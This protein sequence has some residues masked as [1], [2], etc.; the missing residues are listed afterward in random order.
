MQMRSA[1]RNADGL[2]WWGSLLFLMVCLCGCG[3]VEPVVKI[4]LV[5]PF[6]GR[7]RPVGYDV[8]Y[9]GRL[10]VRQV[11]Q[12]G[13][14]GDYRVALV[15][16]D[17]SGDAELA[18]EVAASLAIDPGVVAVIG[19]WRPETTAAAGPI[20]AEAGLPYIDAT[21]LE[22]IDPA[23]LPADFRFAYEAVTPF[24][25]T[26]GEY[27]GPAYADFET[28]LAALAAA[29]AEY[30]RIDRTTVGEIMNSNE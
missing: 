7:Y 5:A 3:S 6:E 15:A 20:Y 22:R 12:A 24:D 25:E 8:I 30:G 27:A 13:G 10:A 28:V 19:H 17:D 14:V 2:V 9:S 11:N 23:G 29:E 1:Q 26:P 21:G 16:L 18:A 4:G